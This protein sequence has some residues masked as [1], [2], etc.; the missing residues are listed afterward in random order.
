MASGASDLG[1]IQSEIP[2]V[3][4][5]R[6]ATRLKSISLKFKARGVDLDK[7]CSKTA[8]NASHCWIT[9]Y[10]PTLNEAMRDA[11]MHVF[12]HAPG[13]L[14]LSS[15]PDAN[16]DH[17]NPEST[18]L[19]SVTLV[20]SLLKEHRCITRLDVGNTA[21]LFCYFPVLLRKALRQNKGLEQIRVHPND[22]RG[23]WSETRAL[24]ILSSALAK[25]SPGL[26]VLEVNELMPTIE[27]EGGVVEAVK[28]GS[29]RRL[30]IRNGT[31]SKI[32]RRLFR[33]IRYSSSLSVLEIEGTRKLALSSAVILSDALRH[34][35]TLR[36]LSIQWL[37]RDAVGTLLQSLER[38]TTLE[39]LALV[40]SYDEPNSILWEGFEALRVNRGLKCL[41]LVGV[42]LISSCALI[43]ADILREND[44]LQEVCLS[45]NSITDLGAG[46]LAKA[47]QQ[48]STL[49]R[50]DISDCTLSCDSLS[51][52]VESFSLN[53]TVE[54]VRL[55]AV[56]IP[57]TWTPSSPLT[58]NHCARLDVT[59]NVPCLEDWAASL[60]EREYHFS[61]LCVG[62]TADAKLSGVV[63]WFDA[64]RAGGVSL[65]ELVINCP[66]AVSQDCGDAVVSFLESTSSLKKLRVDLEDH[67][68]SY[69]A[70]II[71]G[72]ARNRSVCEAKFCQ[73][74]IID[75]VAKALQELLRRNRTLQRLAF[76]SCFFRGHAIPSIARVL[77]DNFVL[78]SFD[79]DDPPL[80]SMYP[81]LRI[82]DRNQSLLNRAVECVLN[83]SVDEESIRALR[84]LSTSDSL[85]DAVAD[86][87][88][89]GREECRS[90][91]QESVRRLQSAL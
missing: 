42:N 4:F 30:V 8:D 87:S 34:N 28:K 37:E 57:E 58:A 13:K 18:L 2:C 14:A 9:W 63:N 72:L 71:R 21:V 31:S 10:L 27:S 83:S 7:P 62:W 40:Y 85:L 52:F 75:R 69:V 16:L 82:T 51:S 20:Y 53:T 59:W 32:E 48:N 35:K 70:A 74:Y 19:E 38:N 91:V 47:L 65:T 88:G 77:E 5:G 49:K 23:V 90:L 56:D 50:L 24:T 3:D 15:V 61:R 66:R 41:K 68:Y 29:L 1:G 79:F 36:K 17:Q 76:K 73:T 81:I 22:V 26:D 44:A 78:L 39:E 43:I 33:A 12:E 25:L 86:V 84:L 6:L 67:S 60:R 45:E 46:A 80:V 89:I 54:C 55:G 11:A 64:L